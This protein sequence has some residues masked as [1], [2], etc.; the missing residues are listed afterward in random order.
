MNRGQQGPQSCTRGP[1][2]GG[3]SVSC[4]RS[5]QHRDEQ[6]GAASRSL[7][8]RSNALLVTKAWRRVWTWSTTNRC[9][10]WG[11]SRGSVASCVDVLRKR[12]LG[13]LCRWQGA[14]RPG[15]CRGQPRRGTGTWWLQRA[16]PQGPG[17][18][19]LNTG[20]G[21]TRKINFWQR[22]SQAGW[23]TLARWGQGGEWGM[24]G[25]ISSNRHRTFDSCS[26]ELVHECPSVCPAGWCHSR[27]LCVWSVGSFAVLNLGLV[28]HLTKLIRKPFKDWFMVS[29]SRAVSPFPL[30][31][32]ALFTSIQTLLLP[33]PPTSDM[34]HFPSSCRNQSRRFWLLFES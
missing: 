18:L 10:Y 2:H 14:A 1:E 34:N 24:G 11:H 16:F 30:S 27:V 20:R 3:V 21:C 33:V 13:E 6:H 31:S 7:P 32:C 22:N 23:G 17:W 15:S 19:V 26:C 8:R 28:K 25:I 29:L 5:K 9:H 12:E 4:L